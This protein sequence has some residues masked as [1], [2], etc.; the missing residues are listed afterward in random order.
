MEEDENEG[1]IVDKTDP[2][3]PINSFIMK[4]HER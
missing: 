4:E 2:F 3:Y 1:L